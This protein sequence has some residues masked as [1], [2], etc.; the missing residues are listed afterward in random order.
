MRKS[1]MLASVAMFASLSVSAISAASAAETKTI[2]RTVYTIEDAP[3]LKEGVEKVCANSALKLSDK[4]K[5]ACTS[6]QFP[7]VTKAL[8][9][10]NAGIGAE[11]NT[12][13]AQ[14]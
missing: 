5:I 1:I 7:S 3:G 11:F 6:K 2:T 13:I 8:K 10:R 9:F 4:A 12:L 14:Q